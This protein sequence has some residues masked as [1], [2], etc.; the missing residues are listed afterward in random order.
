MSIRGLFDGIILME[1]NKHVKG[2]ITCL[3]NNEGYI[4]N[5]ENKS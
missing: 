3:R 4:Q 5:I 2:D 1:G